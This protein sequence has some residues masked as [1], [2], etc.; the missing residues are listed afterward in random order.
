METS[1]RL[2]LLS[3]GLVVIGGIIWDAWRKSN[4][5]DKKMPPRVRDNINEADQL[6][7]DFS[8]TYLNEPR[9][10][11]IEE[12]EENIALEKTMDFAANLKIPEQ[13]IVINVLAKPNCRFTGPILL[14][15]FKALDL[16]LNK[17]KIFNFYDYANM[18]NPIVF[19]VA[20]AVEP[21]IFDLKHMDKF[22]TK[23]LT[24][25]LKLT[26]ENPSGQG[27]ETMLRIARQL[28]SKLDGELKDVNREPLTLNS[29]DGI[30]QQIKLFEQDVLAH[31]VKIEHEYEV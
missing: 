26:P 16:R 17:H 18:E 31:E 8:E 24:F 13:I 25:F 15:A 19:S 6:I 4:K 23:G 9:F 12:V 1:L 11:S 29:I 27:F 5:N 22:S 14:V 2:V 10:G 20:S 3:L 21:G 28:A 7:S 30:R